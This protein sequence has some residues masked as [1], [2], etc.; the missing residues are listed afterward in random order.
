MNVR[1]FQILICLV[2]TMLGLAAHGQSTARGVSAAQAEYTLA[3]RAF[4][5]GDLA[6]ASELYARILEQHGDQALAWFRV[7][8]I[9]HRQQAF[10][11]ALHAYDKALDCADAQVAGTP[12][13][14]AIA[15]IRFNRALLLMDAAANDLQ[16]IPPEVLSKDMETTREVVHHHVSSALLSAGSSVQLD[17]IKKSKSGAKARSYVYTAQSKPVA[18]ATPAAPP[19]SGPPRRRSVAPPAISITQ[20]GTR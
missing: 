16:S 1:S 19:A 8:L 10:R 13:E 20:P 17:P 18:D 7:G 12:D 5:T 15:K 14:E 2:L 3:E 6:H 9:H 11:P 4:Q